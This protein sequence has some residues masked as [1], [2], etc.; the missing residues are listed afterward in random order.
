M[1]RFA[2]QVI[3]PLEALQR[4]AAPP[5]VLPARVAEGTTAW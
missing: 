1:E 4:P 5:P 3:H 2:R